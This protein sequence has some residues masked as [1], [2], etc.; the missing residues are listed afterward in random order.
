MLDGNFALGCR[1]GTDYPYIHIFQCML[2]GTDGIT[3]EI[4]EPFTFVLAYPTVLMF[5]AC[6]FHSTNVAVSRQRAKPEELPEAMIFRTSG[7]RRIE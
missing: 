6:Q 4:L 7:E 1:S 2:E 3:N 5:F